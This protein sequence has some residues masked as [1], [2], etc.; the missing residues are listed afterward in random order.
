MSRV[1]I[2]RSGNLSAKV[3]SSTDWESY[4]GD[5]INDY[6]ICGLALSAGCG[7]TTDVTAGNARVLG[8]HLENTVSCTVICLSASMCNHIYMLVC[9]DACCKPDEWTFFTNTVGGSVTDAMRIGI[10]TTNACAVTSVCNSVKETRRF[11]GIDEDPSFGDGSDG[12]VTIT[13]NTDLMC[14]NVLSTT[15]KF[16]FSQK[17]LPMASV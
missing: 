16:S 1:L 7:L 11:K 5:L 10:A 8:L 17:K 14:T 9:R 3:V 12:D 6:V 4:F 2:P 13:S 15:T